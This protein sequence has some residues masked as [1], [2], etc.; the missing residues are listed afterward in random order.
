MSERRFP[1]TARK[2]KKAIEQGDLAKSP[3]LSKSIALCSLIGAVFLFRKDFFKIVDIFFISFQ[4]EN[5]LF[6]NLSRF[7]NLFFIS[8]LFT[9]KILGISSIA[10]LV[11]EIAQV[12]FVFNLSTLK[13]RMDRANLLLGL[14]K[15]FFIKP[16]EN[17][18]FAFNLVCGLFKPLICLLFIS[19]VA[20]LGARQARIEQSFYIISA[21]DAFLIVFRVFF[22][23]ITVVAIVC[24]VLS[25]LEFVYLR[26]QRTQRLKMTFEELKQE[27]KE[28][29]SN[30]EMVAQRRHCHQ[31][32]AIHGLIQSVRT[33][34]IVLID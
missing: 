5:F 25:L 21:E 1:P 9:I 17:S 2:I 4:I 16:E 18:R 14:K 33:K 13:I 8:F 29:E 26:K 22:Y 31:E 27:L 24:I 12:G 6:F 30:P 11:F 3:N 10:A 7:E 28:T 19:F 20:Y 34:K 23:V 15:V 32:I